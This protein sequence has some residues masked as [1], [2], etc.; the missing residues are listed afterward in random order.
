MGEVRRPEEFVRTD[1]VH[2]MAERF[3]VR[4]TG[5][6]TL[7]VKIIAG[8]FLQRHPTTHGGL[9]HGVHAIE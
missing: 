1:E 8:Q 9:G 4:V 5:N 6:L 2:N 3:L 7:P